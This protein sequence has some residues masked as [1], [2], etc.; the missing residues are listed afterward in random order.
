M[1]RILCAHLLILIIATKKHCFLIVIVTDSS[2]SLASRHEF[3]LIPESLGSH[4]AMMGG[5]GG[6]TS[7]SSWLIGRIIG[8]PAETVPADVVAPSLSTI[9]EITSAF[10][11]MAKPTP[12]QNDRKI[13][14][15]MVQNLSTGSKGV[16]RSLVAK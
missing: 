4:E 9:G 1:A 6:S 15:L 11:R 7:G 5:T 3:P 2:N 14:D 13:T 8:I 16:S 10:S 12:C